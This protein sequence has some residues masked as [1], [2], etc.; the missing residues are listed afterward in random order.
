[1]AK[2]R[3]K[4]GN[5]RQLNQQNSKVKNI[6]EKLRSKYKEKNKPSKSTLDNNKEKEC[7]RSKYNKNMKDNKRNMRA[8]RKA[9]QMA[10]ETTEQKNIRL[11]KQRKLHTEKIANETPEQEKVRLS[12]QKKYCSKNRIRT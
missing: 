9:E 3:K 2:K 6:F 12:A 7:L 10:H 1:M 4:E 8:K 5:K 11:M